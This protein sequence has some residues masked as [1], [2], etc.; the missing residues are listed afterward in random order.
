MRFRS[1]RHTRGCFPAT[2][3]T[4]PL[5]KRTAFTLIELLVVIAIIGVLISLLLPAVQKVREAANRIKCAN[6]LKQFG[7]AFHNYHDAYDRFPMGVVWDGGGGPYCGPAPYYTYPRSSWNYHL[8]PFIEQDNVYRLLP[9][10]AAQNQWEPWGSPEALNPTGPTRAII[11]LA[12]CPSD[13]GALYDSQ[14]WGVFTLSNYHVLFGGFNLAGALANDPSERGA[15]GIN[16]GA[17]LTEITDGTSTTMI[18]SE[19]LRSTGAANDQRG[20]WWG[21]QP[22]YGEIYTQLSPNSTSPDLLYVGWCNNQ[23]Q[24]NLPC[25]SGDYG[26]NNTAAAR[27][28][29]TGGV[30]ALFGDGAVHFMGQNVDLVGVWRPLATAAGGEVIANF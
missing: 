20:L 7:L 5:A 26:P 12:L 16:Y 24:Q 30:N 29:H 13:T 21:D 25:I 10:S 1:W 4:L 18:M 27:S 3:M 11:T 19:Y 22:G 6:N 9:P 2:A 15:F 28:R 14:A 17:A 23:P 8:F